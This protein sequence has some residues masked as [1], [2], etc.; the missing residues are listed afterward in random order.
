V[1]SIPKGSVGRRPQPFALAA[2]GVVAGALVLRLWGV[3]EGLPYAFNV[4]ENAHFVPKAIG[5]FGHSLNP[6]YFVNPPGFTYLLHAVFAL[7]FGGGGSAAHAYAADP[8]EVFTVARAVSAVLGALAVWFVCL[9][10]RRLFDATVGLLAGGLLAVAFLPVFYAHQATNDGPALA[11]I[12]LGL[13]GTAGI[14][15]RGARRDYLIAGVGVGIAAATKYTGGFV[16]LAIAA[17]AIVR[18][19]E[20]RRSVGVA[21]RA[22]TRA[23]IVGLALVGVCALAAFLAAN[24]YAIVDLS[25]FRHDVIGQ[26]AVAGGSDKLGETFTSGY[27]FYLWTAAWGFGVL[28]ALAALMGAVLLVWRWRALAWVLVAPPLAFYVFMGQ[29]QRFFGRWLLPA[30]PF[31]SLLAAFGAVTAVRALVRARRVRGLLARRP[32]LTMPLGAFVALALLA[33]GLLYAVH[34]DRVLARADTR[35]IARAWMVAH[36]P[37]GTPM[38]VEPVAP[39]SWL[40]DPGRS[41]PETASGA[42]W[43]NID[44]TAGPTPA[45]AI[46]V[47]ALSA[48]GGDA[49]ARVLAA[50]VPG[51]AQADAASRPAASLAGAVGAGVFDDNAAPSSFPYRYASD[52][53]AVGDES[54]VR[55]VSPGLIDLLIARDVCLVVTGSTVWGRAYN[56]PKKVP[57]AVAYYRELQRRARVLLRVTPTGRP[58]KFD[59]DWSFDYYPLAYSRPGPEIV[60]Y[61]LRGGRCGP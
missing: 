41:F 23:A 24:P 31:L 60:V 47:A 8:T 45:G 21:E 46:G 6:N 51:G 48:A 30:F 54:Y 13:L 26:G 9:A 27:A 5:F 52:L 32:A 4:D 44:P 36:L 3:G 7:W 33:Q 28:P 14:V 39:G 2:T 18:L 49:I 61:R 17:A 40:A 19:V 29:Q 35:A 37:P 10:G 34:S 20:S 53:S 50:D 42:R 55:R 22:S 59:F 15:R 25:Q 11:P 57:Q 1:R 12:A 43:S 58:Q 16:V 56:E 38:L